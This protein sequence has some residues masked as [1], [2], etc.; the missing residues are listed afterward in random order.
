MALPGLR[1]YGRDETFGG[2]NSGVAARRGQTSNGS[3]GPL[4]GNPTP[5]SGF[6]PRSAGGLIG[7]SDPALGRRL[8]AMEQRVSNQD[9]ANRSLLEQMMK[10]QQDMRME[11]KKCDQSLMEERNQRM[12]L[13]TTLQTSTSKIAE[14]ED[15]LRRTETHA[16]DNKAALVTMISH[17]KNVERAVTLGQQ[18]IMAKK[19]VQGQKIQEIQQ[20]VTTL[21]SSSENLER[22]CH[23]VRE[24]LSDVNGKVDIMSLEL[25]DVK[26]ALTLQDKMFNTQV[27]KLKQLDEDKGT[28]T[29]MSETQKAALESKILQLKDAIME[30]QSKLNHECQ[31]RE[32]DMNTING[33]LD[34]LT[35]SVQETRKRREKDLKE[36]EGTT[37]EL[38]KMS[39]S[40]KQNIVVKISAVQTE[41]KQSLE[42]RDKKI[43]ESVLS[44]LDEQEQHLKQEIKDRTESE[45][46]IKAQIDAQK[47]TVMTY[48]DE[49]TD[50]IYKM[51]T[52]DLEVLRNRLYQTNETCNVF[53]QELSQLRSDLN[54]ALEQKG[55]NH[56]GDIKVLDAKVD[57]LNDRFKLGMNKLQAAVGEN[58]IANN[59]NSGPRDED[60]SIYTELLEDF[61][62]KNAIELNNM[63]DKI[64]AIMRD[65][66]AINEVVEGKLKQ[67][68]QAGEDA[69][70]ILGDKLQQKM[71]SVTFAQERMK[72]QLDD[73][74]DKVQCA[75]TDIADI[76]ERLEDCEQEIA[77]LS[78]S[79]DQKA[80]GGSE[81]L[82]AIKKD[83]D[84]IMGRGGEVDEVTAGVPSLVKLQ[85]EIDEIQTKAKSLSEG[86]EKCKDEFDEKMDDEKKER[87]KAIDDM[88][89]E[90]GRQEKKASNLKEKLKKL[91]G[92]VVGDDGDDDDDK[93]EEEGNE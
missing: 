79:N 27:S 29:K 51:T 53:E 66:R 76:R 22:L 17:V 72:R 19:E 40:E 82:V 10:L 3:Y 57:A 89:K 6:K 26:G 48:M 1:G 21:T 65:L 16:K 87:Q 74:R 8:D 84:F 67:H 34:E 62:E 61:R 14:L 41:L 44:R 46:D 37:R 47:D 28:G 13:T 56:E 60:E 4:T 25:K 23:N 52:A 9:S 24:D 42:T 70:I 90:L 5:A 86:L 77:S 45:K 20:K 49:N 63:E 69:S 75:P 18:D 11:L 35:A 59:G 68:Q 92:D 12:R 85:G 33:R 73:L 38:A 32:M 83:V 58:R 64:D 81:D 91:K 30:C 36:L 54:E 78:G 15:R 31:D 2:R 80:E 71:D 39:E 7:N 55:A 93:D 43:R 50:K 88:R